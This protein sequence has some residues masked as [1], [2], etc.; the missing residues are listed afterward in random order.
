MIEIRL[1]IKNLKYFTDFKNTFYQFILIIEPH[2]NLVMIF[3]LSSLKHGTFNLNY[4]LSVGLMSMIS[5]NLY[6]NG[7]FFYIEKQKG[8]LNI[9]IATPTSLR[10]IFFTRA[11]ANTIVSFIPLILTLV[12][13]RIIF[14]IRIG[15]LFQF[16][17]VL[18]AILLIICIVSVSGLIAFVLG[19]SR[20]AFELQNILISP[21]IVLSGVWGSDTLPVFLRFISYI[22]PLYWGIQI[23]NNLLS[24]KT[25]TII[26]IL[27]TL[28]LVIVFFGVTIL[29]LRKYENELQRGGAYS[30]FQ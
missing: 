25:N 15:S 26:D 14:G 8:I 5:F 1:I 21:I 30:E 4:V 7:S 11:I 12:Y 3:A 17:F 24:G 18:S 9:L 6:S 20:K 27:I 13:S 2:F 19:L 23:C 10:V 29:L 22:N 28:A 16:K